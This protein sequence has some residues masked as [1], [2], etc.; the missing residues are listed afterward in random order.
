MI[1]RSLDLDTECIYGLRIKI[2]KT[3]NRNNRSRERRIRAPDCGLCVISFGY[4]LD[5]RAE[6]RFGDNYDRIR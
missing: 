6:F 1:Y 4:R 2:K 3:D 5:L